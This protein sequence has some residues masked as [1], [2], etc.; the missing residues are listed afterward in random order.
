MSSV[1]MDRPA[2]VIPGVLVNIEDSFQQ[3]SQKTRH[4][5]NYDSHRWAP[6]CSI[7]DTISIFLPEKLVK[8]IRVDIDHLPCQK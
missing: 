6:P 2:T 3:I 7:V 5:Q 8:D 4:F 1:V